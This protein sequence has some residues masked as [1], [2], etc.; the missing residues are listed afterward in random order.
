MTP[1]D[2]D[3]AQMLLAEARNLSTSDEHKLDAAQCVADARSLVPDSHPAQDIIT[4]AR[5]ADSDQ[6]MREM[7]RDAMQLLYDDG[8]DGLEVRP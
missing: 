2:A 8:S 4:R 5:D 6:R 1:D 7:L 3:T